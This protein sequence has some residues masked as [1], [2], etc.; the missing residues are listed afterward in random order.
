MFQKILISAIIFV[1]LDSA[2]L[3][4][5]KS[6]FEQQIQRVQGSP[7]SLAILPTILCY[8]ILIGGLYYFILRENRSWKEAGIL[9]FVIYGVYDTTTLALLK[10]WSWKIAILDTIWGATLFSLTTALTYTVI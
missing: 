9:G 4:S 6:T 5:L 10:N 1:L 7:L 2:Y 3:F 8:I